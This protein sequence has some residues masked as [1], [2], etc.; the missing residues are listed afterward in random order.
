MIAGNLLGIINITDKLDQTGFNQEDVELAQTTAGMLASAL[1]N[2]LILDHLEEQALEALGNLI[3]GKELAEGETVAGHSE[4]VTGLAV[5]IAQAMHLNEQE[6]EQVRRTAF[7]HDL[8]KV[9]VTEEHSGFQ[10]HP[11]LGARVIDDWL[12]DISPGV[13]G[14]H[15]REDGQ[16]FPDG[17]VGEDIP[18]SAKIIA[19][20]LIWLTIG[21]SILFVVS[22]LLVKILLI[23]IAMS[24]TLHLLR[25]KTLKP[26][27]SLEG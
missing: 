15:E 12:S 21:Y 22:F 6:V 3:R 16:G 4:R 19:I 25:V 10:E 17:L 8:G 5:N 20:T 18:L 7:L 13:L 27:D 24:V 11:R 23:L 26:E 1:H 9:V 14:H 2:L